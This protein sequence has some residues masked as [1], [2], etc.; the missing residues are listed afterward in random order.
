LKEHGIH[1]WLHSCGNNYGIMGDLADAG[2]NV[3]HPV[4][5]HTMDEVKVVQEFGDRISFLAGFDVQ[6][7]L[8][9]G[10][11]EEIRSEVRFLIDTFDR[12]DGGMCIAA[13][14]GILPD[15]PL[16]NID[17]FLDEALVYG[18]NKRAREMTRR[19]NMH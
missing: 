2:V 8:P 6:Q 17:A 10:T 19:A 11:P 3:F 4:Q 15:T 13:G 12:P 5:K 1:W 14:N 18:E 16:E 7:I 9:N